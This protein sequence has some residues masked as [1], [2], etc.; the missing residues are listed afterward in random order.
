VIHELDQRAAGPHK[1]LVQ[2]ASGR[3]VLPQAKVIVHADHLDLVIHE[4]PRSLGRERGPRRA[5]AGKTLPVRVSADDD[6]AQGDPAAQS[7][8]EVLYTHFRRGEHVRHV[9]QQRPAHKVRQRV[10]GAVTPAL[11]KVCTELH[12]R[13]HVRM[14]A[15]VVHEGLIG[16]EPALDVKVAVGAGTRNHFVGQVNEPVAIP[17]DR[18]G[19]HALSPCRDFSRL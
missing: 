6:I 15:H 4:P 16:Q 9:Q 17:I 1:D 13:P 14:S 7:A 10:S 3:D 2:S 18:K 11:E 19:G 12:V 8:L 5:P